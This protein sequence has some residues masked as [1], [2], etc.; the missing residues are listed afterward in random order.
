MHLRAP[1]TCAVTMRKAEKT[2]AALIPQP[3]GGALRRG[4]PGNRGGNHGSGRPDLAVRERARYVAEKAKALDVLGKIVS[5][6]ILEMLRAEGETVICGP[7]RSADRIKAAE[8]LLRVAGAVTGP[9]PATPQDVAFVIQ[10]PPK[11]RTAE[12]WLRLH[13]NALA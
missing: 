11:A 5:G 8:V 3:H 4:N 7:T 1:V 12:E 6:D 9:P 13:K 10:V 2:P